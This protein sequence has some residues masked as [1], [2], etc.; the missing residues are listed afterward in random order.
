MPKLHQLLSMFCILFFR[1]LISRAFLDVR[2][3]AI[4]ANIKADNPV[5]KIINANKSNNKTTIDMVFHPVSEFK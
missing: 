2:V 3:K 5:I 1:S 4:T